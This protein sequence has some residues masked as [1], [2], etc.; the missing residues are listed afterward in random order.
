[1]SLWTSATPANN[2]V[3]AGIDLRKSTQKISNSFVADTSSEHTYKPKLQLIIMYLFD[4]NKRE[5]INPN[6]LEG[7]V[8][9]DAIDRNIHNDLM[10][11]RKKKKTKAKS[12][13]M[14]RTKLRN[15]IYHCIDDT[16]PDDEQNKGHTSPIIIDGV[17]AITATV[18][19]EYMQTN[20]NQ[21]W[22]ARDAAEAYIKEINSDVVVTDEMVNNIGKVKCSVYQSKSQ[23]NGI[24]AEYYSKIK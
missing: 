2:G 13:I 1:M 5:Y 19:K 20:M 6:F 24:P 11:R 18:V 22:V 10:D 14:K 9:A 12:T 4:N 8:N 7:M 17:G 3:A 15:F 16:P 21:V 23:Y